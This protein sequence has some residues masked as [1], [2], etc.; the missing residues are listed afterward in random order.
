MRSAQTLTIRRSPV[1]G[2][3]H[4]TWIRLRLRMGRLVAIG[5]STMHVR[6]ALRVVAAVLSGI[7][8]VL[9][10]LRN[11]FLRAIKRVMLFLV[12]EVEAAAGWVR[13]HDR[14]KMDLYQWRA[15]DGVLTIWE[16]QH[17][18]SELDDTF[19]I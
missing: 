9:L 7:A 3:L 14:L 16:C 1:R 2:F 15:D 8:W 6:G 13:S 11:V 4:R 18:C 10:L 12:R 17:C 19:P 5:A